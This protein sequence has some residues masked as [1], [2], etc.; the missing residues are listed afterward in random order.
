MISKS[1]LLNESFIKMRIII[2]F[3]SLVNLKTMKCKHLFLGIFVPLLFY[4]YNCVE[5]QCGLGEKSFTAS[6]KYFTC[7]VIG[8]NPGITQ[9]DEEVKWPSCN[10]NCRNVKAFLASQKQINYFP[11][12]LDVV[13]RDLVLIQITKCQ[14]KEINHDDLKPFSDLHVLHLDENEIETIGLDLFSHNSKLEE[15]HFTLIKIS[16]IHPKVFNNLN[17]LK[18]LSL[19]GNLCI[20]NTFIRDENNP[21]L[22]FQ[23]ARDAAMSCN[24]NSA[25]NSKI[26]TSGKICRDLKDDTSDIVSELKKEIEKIKKENEIKLS[27]KKD[28]P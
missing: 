15:I 18:V 1:K 23:S 28:S 2:F 19:K 12:G 16:S 3:K 22:V 9:R 24:W 20:T 6:H 21:N 10:R 7:E 8:I 5:I 27:N 13:F 11:K 26:D 14:L 17:S 25:K 4:G